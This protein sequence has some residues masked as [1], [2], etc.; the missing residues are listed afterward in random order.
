[1]Q[2][3]SGEQPQPARAKLKDEVF[4]AVFWAGLLLRQ[5]DE[6]NTP[7]QGPPGEGWEET[8]FCSVQGSRDL[9]RAG[10]L[11]R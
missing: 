2:R 1:M 5:A 9:A 11:D 10:Q 6:L 7:P 3:Q 8:G 4:A